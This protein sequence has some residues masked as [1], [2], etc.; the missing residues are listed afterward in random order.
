MVVFVHV[1]AELR[2]QIRQLGLG[3]SHSVFNIDI[4]SSI[5]KPNENDHHNGS[6]EY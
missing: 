5:S 3:Y 1:A 4:E 6:F 2:L